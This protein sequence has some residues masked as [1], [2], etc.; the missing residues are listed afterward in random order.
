MFPSSFLSTS[1]S[2]SLN[3]LCLLAPSHLLHL[4]YPFFF[5]S[6]FASFSPSPTSSFPHFSSSL[7][8]LSVVVSLHLASLHGR[9]FRPSGLSDQ[10][11]PNDGC[12]P[13]W[14][15]F[16]Y[17]SDVSFKLPHNSTAL[18]LMLVVLLRYQEQH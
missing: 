13:N 17:S 2:P 12:W 3:Y 1:T 16:R 11:C 15:F 18:V 7:F 9:L 4:L 8:S 6:I 14:S 5:S 10:P